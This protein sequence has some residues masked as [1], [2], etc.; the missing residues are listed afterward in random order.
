MPVCCR[1]VATL[2]NDLQTLDAEFNKLGE[3]VAKGER[4]DHSKEQ[5]VTLGMNVDMGGPRVDIHP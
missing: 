3:H 2:N 5:L 1:A 4:D